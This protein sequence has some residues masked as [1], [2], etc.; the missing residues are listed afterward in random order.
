[1]GQRAE[2]LA[3]RIEQGAEAV[4]TFAEG[5]SDRDWK[6]PVPPDGRT[7]GVMVHHVASMYPIE[8]DLAKKMASG[9][10][11]SGLSWD[12]VAKVNA[13]HAHDH[14]AA[15][16]QETVALLRANAKAAAAAVRAFTD[17]QLDT[18]APLSLDADAPLTA[19]YFIEGHPVRHSF[20]HL[21]KIRAVLHR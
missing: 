3:K 15:N 1:M 17:A 6:I 7:V 4:A 10:G 5:L 12:D 18:A 9:D 20:H 2:Q 13:A 11:V 16:R 21:S 19:Q 14:A 8:L